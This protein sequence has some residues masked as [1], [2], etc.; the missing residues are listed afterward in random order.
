MSD[1]LQPLDDWAATL[2]ASSRLRVTRQAL[3]NARKLAEGRLNL[4]VVLIEPC[5]SHDMSY[6]E[7]VN[8]SNTFQ[9]I[10]RLI[11]A[12]NS[13]YTLLDVT[14]LDVWSLV[15]KKMRENLAML[16]CELDIN[17]AHGVFE[18]IL[19]L[20]KP[21]VILTLQC[22]TKEAESPIAKSLCGFAPGTPRPS[23]LQLQ[24]HEALVFR[25][26]HP[27]TYLRP[28]YT[29]NLGQLEIDRLKEGLSLCFRSAFLAL[30]GK[31]LVRWNNYTS[32]TTTL[33]PWS[34]MCSMTA[35]YQ[36]LSREDA[37]DMPP[38][39][40]F[41]SINLVSIPSLCKYFAN[42]L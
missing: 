38:D 1:Y 40:L 8:R 16:G 42:V 41:R 30:Q 34:W 26:F 35:E 22:K 27:S 39:H 28:D 20:K 25:G 24:G 11:R 29:A 2:N 33:K 10:D 23:I 15:S 32:T 3:Y 37:K 17:A 31:R 18:E 4:A 9:E 12:C 21:D 6:E 5:N 14:V 7:M 19:L 36:G 13:D